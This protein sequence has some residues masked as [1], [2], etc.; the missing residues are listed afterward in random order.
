MKDKKIKKIIDNIEDYNPSEED[1][2]M[3]GNFADKYMDKSEEDIFVEIIRVKS[4]I[5]EQ[6]SD[7]QYATILEKLESIRPMLSEEQN[8]K[9]DK[10]LELLNKNK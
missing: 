4:E 9:L 7:E 3:I 10:I 6:M 5:G 1:I 8:A 2:L